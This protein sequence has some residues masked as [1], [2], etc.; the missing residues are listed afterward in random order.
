M[1]AAIYVLTQNNRNVNDQALLEDLL[2]CAQKA[3]VG[4][5]TMGIY[6]VS[7]RYSPSTIIRRFRSWNNALEL[8]GLPIV[9]NHGI[10]DDELFENL[11]QIWAEVGAQPKYSD[12]KN[13]DLKSKF[14]ARTY[15]N[16]F[17][18]WRAALEAF[19][20]WANEGVELAELVAKR[21][22]QGRR[23]TSTINWRLRA[24]V[25]MRDSARC[26]LC[27]RTPQ[28]G[29]R[30]HVD[31]S[32]PWSKGGETVL[33]NL[34]ILCEQCNIGKSDVVIGGETLE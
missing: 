26:Q 15:A 24:L 28:D 5:L 1:S 6:K 2:E 32:H 18:G 31:H 22:S 17:G 12:L 11:A 3:E 7:G 34:R 9:K 21:S 23:T 10:D 19:V 33:E 4:F 20:I 27:G 14:G 8:A 16:R 30:L 25:L 13:K 29:F